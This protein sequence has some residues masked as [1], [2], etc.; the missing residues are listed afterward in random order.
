MSRDER[1]PALT[2]S[3]P[4]GYGSRPTVPAL[5]RSTP[6]ALA[7][8]AALAA[9]GAPPS[10][11][12]APLDRFTF[13]IA[14]GLVGEDLLVVS[15]NF[16][17]AYD[18]EDGGSVIAV[19]AAASPAAVRGGGV[20][21]PSFAGEL[22]L[23]DAAACGLPRTEALVPVREGNALY[24]IAVGAQGALSCGDGCRV[25]LDEDLQDPYGVAVVCRATSL[26]EPRA[27]AY[28]GFLRTA[29]VR[30]RIVELDLRTGG[31]RSRDV[32][33]GPVR[34]F[35]YDELNDRLYFTSIDS[36]SQAP[37]RWM[38]LA[39]DCRFDVPGE[40]EPDEERARP[41]CPV[42]AVDLAAYLRGIEL[43]GIALS[44]PQPGRTRRAF[45]AG[46]L[47]NAD[48]AST[49][50]GRPGFDVG[51]VL[52]VLDLVEGRGG[53]EPRLAGI[54]DVGL[55]ANEVEALPLRPGMGDVVAVTAS[56]D[57]LLW[58]YDDEQ[59]AL[60]R[61]FGR[62]PET[63]IPV[64]GRE[65]FGLAVRD[66]GPDARLFV[67]SFEDGFVTP[68]RVPL[69]APWAAERLENERIGVTP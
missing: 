20:R 30:G 14:L 44:H 48:L 8:A 68:V 55:G 13:P 60:V 1:A 59:E 35:A 41:I 36:G 50:G 17:L 43:R 63:G 24:R 3:R 16:D 46:R 34:S 32:G 62:S 54:H 49:I 21:I 18:I 37:L 40:G 11:D 42:Q 22:A 53:V 19:D 12:P 56:D 6:L 57:G 39:G 26:G 61:V 51:G 4:R 25:G 29:Q 23:A 66:D 2:A 7:L 31:T 38:E 45:V 9:C 69:D 64:L 58:L 15:T 52:M 67:S 5:S 27:R 33:P 10:A 28:V 65:P 47:Y